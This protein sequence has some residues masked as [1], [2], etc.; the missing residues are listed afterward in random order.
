LRETLE[1]ITRMQNIVLELYNQ[2]EWNFIEANEDFGLGYF[3]QL[4]ANVLGNLNFCSGEFLDL[5][6]S[7]CNQFILNYKT[8][9]RDYVGEYSQCYFSLTIDPFSV[10]YESIL[11]K[12]IFNLIYC[13]KIIDEKLPTSQVWWVGLHYNMIRWN[14]MVLSNI[15]KLNN[16]YHGK[17]LKLL[18][19]FRIGW[20]GLIG[21]VKSI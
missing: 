13:I 15:N 10:R 7:I 19:E 8:I 4:F 3:D 2:I 14:G 20:I 17:L 11:K 18:G 5:F 16:K 9:L 21:S 1:K 6:K 12:E